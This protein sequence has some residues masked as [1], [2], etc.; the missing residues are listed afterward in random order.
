MKYHLKTWAFTLSLI[1]SSF[2]AFGTDTPE[3]SHVTF[4]QSANR[5]VTISYDLSNNPGIVTLDIQTNG[6]SIGAENFRNIT[7]E[8]NQEVPVG[9]HIITWKP[10]KSWPNHKVQNT[11][12]KVSAWAKSAPPSY[13]TIE[14]AYPYG[15]RW[16]TCAE[17]LPNGIDSD[18][19]RENLLLMR[20]IDQP[21]GGKWLMGSPDGGTGPEATHYVTL[22]ND[23]WMGVFQ[24][25]QKQWELVTGTNHSFY[26]G[27]NWT[28]RPV[29]Q[30]SFQ[31]IR[32]GKTKVNYPDPPAEGTFLANLKNLTHIPFDLPSEMQW[33]YACRAGTG[34]SFNNGKEDGLSELG[35][36]KINGGSTNQHARVGSY[37]PNA[38]GLYDMHGNV[39]ELCL[40]WYNANITELD[41][42][43]NTEAASWHV[44]R[45]GSWDNGNIKDCRSS[46]RNY[47][48][49][50]TKNSRMGLRLA[51]PIE[52]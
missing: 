17:A 21:E 10:D 11:R 27:D 28:S 7:G 8:V 29:E 15:I 20:R 49:P 36:Y 4:T 42:R 26:K 18:I 12:A 41:G 52:F 5:L 37:L 13:M 40:D 44:M 48:G 35:R 50:A 24:V 34:S 51:C 23:Y 32:V 38:W 3:I 33:E 30:V 19:Y 31:D 22:T 39:W 6:V 9:H 46:R 2:S 47:A 25:T 14:L 45:G 43:V 1:A 16:Y